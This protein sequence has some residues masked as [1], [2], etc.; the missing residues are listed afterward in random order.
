MFYRE[1]AQPPSRK[2]AGL[3][4][5][6]VGLRFDPDD[7]RKLGVMKWPYREQQCQMNRFSEESDSVQLNVSIEPPTLSA[8]I[9]TSP[10]ASP[11]SWRWFDPSLECEI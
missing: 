8:A 7:Y 2:S 6:K 4:N 11:V 9:E 1:F 5:A 3:Y 10:A